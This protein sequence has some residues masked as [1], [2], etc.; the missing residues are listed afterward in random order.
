MRILLVEDNDS[1]VM[2]V[3][4]LLHGEGYEVCSARNFAETLELMGSHSFDLLLLDVGLPDGDGFALCRRIREISPVPVIFLTARDEEVDVVR[5][6][7]LGADDYV[8]K[9]FRNRE[10]ISRIKSVLRRNGK[11]SK[12][13]SCRGILL[14]TETGRVFRCGEEI[15]L[16]KLEYRILLTMMSSPGRLFSREEILACVWDASGNFVNDNTLSVTMK[17]I[18]EKIGDRDCEIIR[19]VRGLGYRLEA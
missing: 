3:E 13:L 16:T 14:N 10:L 18:R 7:D 2:G 5:G 4:Y 19:T 6:F 8:M 17:R 11:S 12:S 1:I 9:P 15:V